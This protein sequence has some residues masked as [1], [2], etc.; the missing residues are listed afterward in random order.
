MKHYPTQSTTSLKD[1]IRGHVRTAIEGACSD[2]GNHAADL[3][4]DRL[5]PRFRCT[6]CAVKVARDEVESAA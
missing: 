2:C 5:Q 1:E 6:P 4:M 3:Y